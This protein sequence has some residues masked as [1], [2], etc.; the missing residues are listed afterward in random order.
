MRTFL[1][2][3]S[4][5][6]GL[7]ACAQPAGAPTPPEAP[8]IEILARHGVGAFLENI[9]VAGDGAVYYTNYKTKTLEVWREGEGSRTFAQLPDHPVSLVILPD[10]FAVVAHGSSIFDGMDFLNSNRVLRLDASGAVVSTHPAP[11]S[12]FMNGS[13][14]FD[15]G[16]VLIADSV[17][18]AVWRFDLDSG[19]F[20]PF[21]ADPVLGPQ[22]EFPG[23]N[24]LKM[25]AGALMISSSAQRAIY[26]LPLQNG[27]PAGP[28]TAAVS[29]L[30][31]ADDFALLPGGELL[32]TTHEPDALVRVGTDGSQT[33]LSSDPVLAGST[34]VA[35]VGDAERRRALVLSTGGVTTGGAGEAALV[36]VP[37]P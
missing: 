32:V 27:V 1:L 31:G 20:S 11:Q 15:E 22:G 29:G 19:A 34:A 12:G 8:Q 28:L 24:G 3:G 6:F 18:G 33:V 35:V 2:L 25:A 5:A 13:V 7:G 17:Q 10:G 9:A 26:R 21:F 23:A 4:A 16:T 14:L 37:L 30:P 36:S